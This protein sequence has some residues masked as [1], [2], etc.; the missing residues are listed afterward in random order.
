[1]FSVIANDNKATGSCRGC[2]G[3]IVTRVEEIRK[4]EE[5]D[6]EYSATALVT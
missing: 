3:R 2:R 1:M 4:K 5:D 6:V